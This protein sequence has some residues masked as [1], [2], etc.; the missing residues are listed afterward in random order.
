MKKEIHTPNPKIAY[1]IRRSCRAKL[2]RISVHS[3]GAVTVTM[4]HR[5]TLRDAER[6]V[7]K[8]AKW[9]IE[10]LN[11]FKNAKPVYLNDQSLSFDNHKQSA[12]ERV[13]AMLQKFNETYHFRYNKIRIKNHKSRWGS[14]SKKGNLNFNYRIALLPNHL[15]EYIVVHELCHLKELN[16]SKRF[17]GL[18]AQTLPDHKKRRAELRKSHRF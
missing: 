8:K 10:K 4:P 9:I 11:G 16:H 1:T 15:A 6:W 5:A 13:E 3:N 17:W 18:V 2:L 14:C 12:Q 7:K